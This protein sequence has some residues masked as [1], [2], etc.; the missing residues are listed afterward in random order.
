MQHLKKHIQG[1]TKVMDNS[2]KFHR[3]KKEDFKE[4][5]WRKKK[6]MHAKNYEDAEGHVLAMH[7]VL[8]KFIAIEE[9]WKQIITVLDLNENEIGLMK[10]H[11][12]QVKWVK[13]L[14]EKRGAA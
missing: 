5:I 12:K 14:W 13:T 9:T 3:H 4:L 8:S 10:T 6:I 1:I 11:E 7:G 2:V